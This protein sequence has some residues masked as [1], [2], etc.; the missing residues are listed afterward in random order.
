MTTFSAKVLADSEWC[1]SRITSLQL[2]YPR[3]IHSQFMTHR[4]FS[5]NA[6]SSRA[7]PVEKMLDDIEKDPVLP[8]RWGKNQPGMQAYQDNENSVFFEDGSQLSP[9][10]SWKTAKD[11]SC[12]WARAFSKG[13]FHKQIVNRLTEPFQHIDVVVTS[14]EW[15]NFFDL[16]LHDDAQPE[17]QRLAEVIDAA[18]QGSRP[19]SFNDSSLWHLP[20]ITQDDY[21]ELYH[22]PIGYS[23]LRLVSAARCARVSYRNHDK[24]NPNIKKDIELAKKLLESR[25]MSPFEHQAKPL[26]L[27]KSTNPGAWEKGMTHLDRNSIPWSGNLKGWIQHRHLL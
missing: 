14:T 4:V 21:E 24:S 16:R 2:R 20:Y 7:I 1:G 17:I 3:F 25:H 18:I 5:R 13:G 6:S 22:G 12:F 23:Q 10:T 9:E 11:E 27:I 26:P 8:L 19:E 15:T